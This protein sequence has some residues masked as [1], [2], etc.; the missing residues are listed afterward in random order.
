MLFKNI[1][2][3]MVK[4]KKDYRGPGNAILI[5]SAAMDQVSSWYPDKKHSLFTYYFLKGLQGEADVNKDRVITTG[6]IEA[7][8]KENV[9]YWALRLNGVAQNPVVT[10]G[11]S[12]VLV[13]LKK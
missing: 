10:G 8:L 6:E 12:E 5:T 1:S 11:G 7:Y 3:A 9:S 2:P 13:E 4:V